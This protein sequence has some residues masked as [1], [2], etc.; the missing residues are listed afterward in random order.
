[1]KTVGYRKWMLH[2]D[3]G[4]ALF[5]VERG[6]SRHDS[7]TLFLHGGPGGASSET[8]LDLV[9]DGFRAIAF[10]Q[11]GCGRSRPVRSLEDNTTWHVVDDIERLRES[12]GLDRLRIVAGS[13]GAAL[14][15]I[16]AARYPARVEKM[17]LYSPFL[18]SNVETEHF[19]MGSR[20]ILP[21][22]W[23]R[24]F[25]TVRN[26]SPDRIIE[27]FSRLVMGPVGPAQSDACRKWV[28]YELQASTLGAETALDHALLQSGFHLTYAQVSCHYFANRFFLQST[29]CLDIAG[30]LDVPVLLLRGDS[31]L[32]SDPQT[33]ERLARSLPRSRLHM[34]PGAGHC[35]GA[36]QLDQRLAA[37]IT[38]DLHDA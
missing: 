20:E 24:A 29:S 14:A 30:S 27:H 13:W 31:D 33:V 3:P 32:V 16:Y 4:H 21:E 37:L 18:G 36:P 1:M 2:V 10:D 25:G 8:L 38:E 35:G 9:P 12:V 26:A 34:I 23:H 11:R 5:C 6:V 28:E 19:L 17:L 15:L 22:V 7:A